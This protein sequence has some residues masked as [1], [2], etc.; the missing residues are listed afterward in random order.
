MRPETIKSS[1]QGS[2]YKDP[3]GS[4]KRVKSAR[5]LA[6]CT[7]KHFAEKTGISAATLRIWEEPSLE[8]GGIS[9]KGAKRFI[10][11][12]HECG[13][14]CTEDWLL[15]GKGTSPTILN[16]NNEK[17]FNEAEIVS[18]GEEESILKDIEAFKGN[19]PNPIVAIINDG[20]MLPL[21]SYGDYVGGIKRFAKDI[22]SLVGSNCI[23]ELP[24]MTL[25]RKITRYDSS[26]N[27]YTLSILNPDTYTVEPI[28]QT[29]NIISAAKVVWYRCR[30]KTKSIVV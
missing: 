14:Y 5:M 15:H 19:N 29:N 12:L 20:S 23:I 25:V 28:I 27:K 8:R 13:I 30:E 10:S 7:R 22:V 26:E 6:G 4:G 16:F 9:K 2:K 21:Y 1:Y 24:N 11:A 3:M 18:W 17:L